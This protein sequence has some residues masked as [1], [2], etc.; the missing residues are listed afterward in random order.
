MNKIDD[1]DPAAIFA[2][3]LSLHESAC[4]AADLHNNC[5]SEIYNGFD[6]FMRQCMR[7]ATEFENWACANVRWES[8]LEV[9]PYLLED[10]FGDAALVV[11]GSE[12]DVGKLGCDDWLRIARML[13]LPLRDVNQ[14]AEIVTCPY[15]GENGWLHQVASWYAV[16]KEDQ[17]NVADLQEWQCHSAVCGGKSFWL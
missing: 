9:W 15:C 3:A 5:L 7:V 14:S 8:V 10:R 13:K 2:A 17:D 12:R 11:A 4:I 16:S 1:P 6:E